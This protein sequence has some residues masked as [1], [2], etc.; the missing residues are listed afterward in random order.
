MS[1]AVNYL[2]APWSDKS[3]P[4]S[5]PD[6]LKAI[7]RRAYD[8]VLI[9]RA[10]CSHPDRFS[11]SL[12]ALTSWYV[13]LRQAWAELSTW[14][15]ENEV[16][17]RA[18][19]PLTLVAMQRILAVVQPLETG[20]HMLISMRTATP[21]DPNDANLVS[22]VDT[23]RSCATRNAPVHAHSLLDSISIPQDSLDELRTAL[24]VWA[25]GPEWSRRTDNNDSNGMRTAENKG[26]E[27]PGAASTNLECTSLEYSKADGVQQ[28]AKKFGMSPSTFRNRRRDGKIRV[29]EVTRKSIR[30]ALPDL[31][32]HL[33][34]SA[35]QT[36]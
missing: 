24:S 9:A 20:L 23:I 32:A 12:E 35:R 3:P 4:A 31:P 33:R 11:Y 30:V 19:A 10:F 8:V 14:L 16:R 22:L 36:R 6:E 26:T 2:F 17:L 27:K 25:Q 21:A 1:N 29:Q 13:P 28:W 5:L 34:E 7:Y 15:A 18:N